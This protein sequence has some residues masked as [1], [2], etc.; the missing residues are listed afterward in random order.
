MK[1]FFATNETAK[2]DWV[3]LDAEGK[4]L[5]RL[6]TEVARRLRGKHKPEFT[7]HADA[8]DYVIVINAAKVR[9]TGNKLEGK[10]YWRHTGHPGGLKSTTLGKLQ[11]EHPERV[12]EKAVKGMLPRGP[13]GYAQYRKLKVYAGAEHPHEAQQPKTISL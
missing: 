4:V 12:I 5:G 3:V 7:P 9:T 6:A 11:A 8:G 13:L 1:T 2:R 10:V